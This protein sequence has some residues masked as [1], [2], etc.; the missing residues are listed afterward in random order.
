MNT[1]LRNHPVLSII[2]MTYLGCGFILLILG[3]LDELDHPHNGDP[4]S[5]WKVIGV[6]MFVL[7]CGP[8][9]IGYFAAEDTIK[10]LFKRKRKCTY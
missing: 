6:I 4:V 2:A 10:K 9:M 5:T 1:L 3:I 8:A 7:T